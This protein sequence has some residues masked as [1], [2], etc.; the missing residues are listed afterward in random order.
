MIH[1]SAFDLFPKLNI[2]RPKMSIEKAFEKA[3]EKKYIKRI[4]GWKF[5]HQFNVAV[6]LAGFYGPVWEKNK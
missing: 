1:T 2:M 6:Y 3:K 4:K 5:I